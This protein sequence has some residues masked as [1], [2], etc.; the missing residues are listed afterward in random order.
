MWVDSTEIEFSREQEDVGTDS[1]EVAVATR[2]ALQRLAAWS[3]PLM[4][5]R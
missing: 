4:A 2:F 3:K 1:G 5:S